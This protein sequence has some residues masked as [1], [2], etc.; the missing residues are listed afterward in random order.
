MKLPK[1]WHA[2]L[3]AMARDEGLV[4]A[5]EPAEPEPPPPMSTRERN[6]FLRRLAVIQ[7]EWNTYSDA[8]AER[9]EWR[10]DIGTVQAALSAHRSRMAAESIE[11]PPS[12]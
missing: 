2:Q 7:R 8:L 1:N 12:P 4:N 10:S 3:E 6:G 5:P 9:P 11:P